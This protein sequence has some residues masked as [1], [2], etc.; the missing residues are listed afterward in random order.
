[1]SAVEIEEE[2]APIGVGFLDQRDF[3]GAKPLLDPFLP[4]D[5][6]IDLVV[7]LDIE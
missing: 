4:D 6:V 3:P 2:I 5:G 7:M 1:M